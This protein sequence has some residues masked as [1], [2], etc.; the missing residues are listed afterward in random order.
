MK[1]KRYALIKIYLKNET[2]E[3]K[4]LR[5]SFNVKKSR[6]A[7]QNEAEIKIYN[8][9]KTS[10]AK[11]K[12]EGSNV[13][14]YAGYEDDIGLIFKGDTR[15]IFHK[16][17][18]ADVITTITAGDGDNALTSSTVNVTLKGELTLKAYIEQ[19][20]NRLE[21]I[22][23]GRVVGIDDLVGNRTATTFAGHVRDELDRLALKYDFNYTIENH[24]IDIV[25][26]RSH[27][28]LSEVVSAET[29][30]LETAVLRENGYIEVKTLLNNNFK[31]NDLFRLESEFV[32]RDFRIE[33]VDFVGDT[34]STQ[35][36]SI[37]G[38]VSLD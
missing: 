7:E 9:S 6:T 29:G 10:Q 5:I 18:G 34:H 25:R 19:L 12:D 4:E 13:E 2:I 20:V 15:E 8:L 17:E 30:M 27:T 24:T 33:S 23:L 31:C 32:K 37:L 22:K 16:R 3:I 26:N 11:I 21:N 28:G 35:W 14:L 38:G 1:F 36:E